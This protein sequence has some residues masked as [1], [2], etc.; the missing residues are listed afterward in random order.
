MPK[1]G[2]YL[3][4]VG[5]AFSR[6]ESDT[7][8]QEFVKYHSFPIYF[9]V[10]GGRIVS[11]GQT[12]DQKFTQ[13]TEEDLRE[14]K[15]LKP[16]AVPVP[17]DTTSRDTT[18]GK[19]LGLIIQQTAN[20]NITVQISGQIRHPSDLNIIKGVPDVGV[21][22]DWDY[23]NN[24]NTGY[25]PYYGGNTQHVDYDKTDNNGYYYF[26][27]TF[28]GSQP[29]NQYSPRIRVYANNANSAAFDGD[30]GNGAK[31]PVYYYIDISSATTY[32]FSNTAH[33]TVETNQG[34]AL[35]N[36]YRARVFSLNRLSFTP[37]QIRYYIRS[38]TGT[39]FCQ[40]G[41]CGGQNLTVPR[42]V[43]DVYPDSE[44][45]YHEYGHFIEY[46]KVGFIPATSYNQPHWFRKQT[47]HITA[48]IEGWAEFY[49]AAAH[50]YWYS[51]ELP[52]Q[53][54]F[55]AGDFE[56]PF[57]KV[58][59][60]MDFSQGT[61]FTNRQNTAVEGAVASFFYSLWDDVA[62]RA[63]NYT[64]DNDDMS[65]SGA[66]LLN[67]LPNR[68][69]VLGQLIGNTQI[70]AYRNALLNALDS[71]NDAS[72]NAWYDA[73]IN[74]IGSARPATPTTLQ[75]SGSGT[76][77]TVTWNDNTCPNTITYQMEG[78]GSYTFDLVENQEQG[79]RVYRKAT[80]ATWD[81]TL[82]GYTLIATVGAN[83]TSW[84][85]QSS[86]TGRHSYVVVAYNGGGNA[87]PKAE[88]AI[89]PPVGVTIT[90]PS[91]LQWK[92]SG[93]WTANPSGGNGSYTYE[94]RYRFACGTGTWSS[95]VSTA[96]SYTRQMPNSD[97]ELQVK[98]T[99]NG[100]IV[101][102]EHCVTLGPVK[103]AASNTPVVVPENFVLL[104][105]YPNPFNPQTAIRFGLPEETQVQL[106]VTDLLGRVVRSLVNSD[107]E[108]GYHSVVWD[109]KNNAGHEV[110]SGVYLY[111]IVAGTF[112][113]Q[114]KLT[115][116]K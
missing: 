62:L 61:L 10:K 55:G 80:N 37:S 34:G 88:F 111:Q 82:N 60:F 72:V 65:Y 6:D 68:Y 100:Q 31:F 38:G 51:V 107:F 18:K 48:W 53:V 112:R 58:Y 92:Q 27:F 50:M 109:G 57:P 13:P 90:G 22:L 21:Y 20:Y 87:L 39:F 86:I 15:E 116:L 102:D 17:F 40:P 5:L 104:Q 94:W 83:V 95:V 52:S 32:V 44:T 43:F 59:Q 16:R 35:R 30:L 49:A 103:A 63:P 106:V 66:F 33:L 69:N 108:A 93:T 36:L 8:N 7:T 91:A 99:S 97:L 46:S 23:D 24:P 67:Q 1:E 105:N 54:E 11:Y 25:T 64:G 114:K 110:P 89:T 71:Q 113:N 4:Q 9:E 81:G 56:S 2:Y 78:W 42:I 26:S 101:Y 77:R 115:L 76:S 73:I 74:R 79:F 14:P 84:T 96:Q 45:G 41:N 28:T 12:P 75:V 3:V 29:A 70:E 85:D 98:V 47:E 19:A